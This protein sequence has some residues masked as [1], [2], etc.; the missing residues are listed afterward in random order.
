MFVVF[1]MEIGRLVHERDVDLVA[2][3]PAQLSA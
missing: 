1:P 2:V 3:W